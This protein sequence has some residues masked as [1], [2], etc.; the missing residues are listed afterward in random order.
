M[1]ARPPANDAKR[2]A[3]H[4]AEDC[5]DPL[6]LLCSMLIRC[7]CRGLPPRY[8]RAEASFMKAYG[9]WG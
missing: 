2:A 7:L 9:S 6:A 4:S 3:I 5:R 1:T 8:C